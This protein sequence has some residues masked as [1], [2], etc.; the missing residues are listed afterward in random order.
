MLNGTAHLTLAANQILS[1]LDVPDRVPAPFQNHIHEHSNLKHQNQTKPPPTLPKNQEIPQINPFLA[2]QR[3]KNADVYSFDDLLVSCCNEISTNGINSE[4]IPPTIRDW[5]AGK[6]IESLPQKLV[7]RL[8]SFLT[9]NRDMSET[10]AYREKV[11]CEV[12]EFTLL[13]YRSAG[14]KQLHES[15]LRDSFT[16]LLRPN[17]LFDTFRHKKKHIEICFFFANMFF[18]EKKIWQ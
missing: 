8:V 9:E 16:T 13:M 12:P 15:L 2:A 11:N 3:S 5:I 17:Y 10:M 1:N 6:I 18:F 4:C 14:T 7:Q